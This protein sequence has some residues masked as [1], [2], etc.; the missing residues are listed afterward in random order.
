MGDIYAD[1]ARVYDYFYPDRTDEVDYWARLAGRYGQRVLDLMCGTA[2]VSLALARR[3][4]RVLGV[5]LSPAMLSVGAE[6]LAAAADYPARYLALAQGE[7]CAIPA[8]DAVFDF[9][10]VGGSG[11]FNHLDDDAFP[12]A[13]GELQRILCPGG[14]LGLELVNPY[15]LKEIYPERT[16]APFRPTPPDVWVEKTVANRFD[17]EAGL[18]HINQVTRYEIAGESGEFRDA[19]ALH[20]RQPGEVQAL[21]AAAGFDNMQVYGDYNLDSF[22]IW[23]FAMLVVAEKAGNRI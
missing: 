13:L 1:W 14:G 5:D 10:L 9:A 7:A 6:R 21:L 23:S 8:P 22:S 2:K 3:G 12:Q 16:F 11:S 15:L 18:F 20:V 17:R 4:Y 19:F